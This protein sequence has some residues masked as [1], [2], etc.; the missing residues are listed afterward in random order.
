MLTL[1]RDFETEAAFNAVRGLERLGL[2]LLDWSEPVLELL[3]AIDDAAA[4]PL[5]RRDLPSLTG[6]TL[7]RLLPGL[8]VEHQ[9][10]AARDWMRSGRGDNWAWDQMVVAIC[11]IQAPDDQLKPVLEELYGRLDDYPGQTRRKSEHL[12]L[13]RRRIRAI[14]SE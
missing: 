8:M 7:S 12:E 1:V 14:E 9:M 6:C 5:V 2:L 11:Q 10:D 4:W 3:V 13:V